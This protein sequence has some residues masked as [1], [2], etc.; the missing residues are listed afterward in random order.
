VGELLGGLFLCSPPARM[1]RDNT[2]DERCSESDRHPRGDLRVRIG[3]VAILRLAADER[4]DADGPR[5]LRLR[6]RVGSAVKSIKPGQFVVGSFATSDN[7]CAHS[8]T[9]TS[10]RASTVS[11]C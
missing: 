2:S 10:L 4:S 1:R 5:V 11:S 6:R 9:V 8:D 3:P 7:T